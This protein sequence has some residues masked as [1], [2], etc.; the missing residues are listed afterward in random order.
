M[1]TIS[2]ESI[3]LLHEKISVT[4]DTIDYFPAFEKSLKD[5]SKKANISGFRPGKVPAG[6][7]K[8]M[9]GAALFSEEVFRAVDTELN[10]YFDKENI[11]FFAQPLPME[12]TDFP[13][14]DMNQPANY[15]FDFEIGLKPDFDLTD[16]SKI[17]LKEY[18]VDVTDEDINRKIENMQNRYAT[19]TETE[20]V[21][22]EDNNILEVTLE[23][24]DIAGN[25][26][27]Q[28]EIDERE[29]SLKKFSDNTR[30]KFYGK[31]TGDS[32]ELILDDTL[33]DDD[34]K[35]LDVLP[36]N[37]DDESAKNKK[38]KITITKVSRL[39]KRALNEAFFEEVYPGKN[40][41]TE[42]DLKAEIKDEM[43]R[44]WA[45]KSRNQVHHQLFHSLTDHIKIDFPETFLRRWLITQNK[46][47]DGATNKTEEQIDEEMPDFLNQLKW[48]VI[49]DKIAKEQSISVSPDEI[50]AF[51]KQQ[52]SSYMGIYF[53]TA[54]DNSW[55]NEYANRMLQDKKYVTETYN[56][57]QSEKI[58]SWAEKQ[59]TLIPT[60]IST[61]DFTTVMLEHNAQHH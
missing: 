12:T 49:S 27:E 41:K 5:Y 53:P 42:D 32:I 15:T 30:K 37:E 8:K 59:I 28:N 60:S 29:I 26:N 51:A 4:L 21:Q 25:S 18:Q 57:L 38:L 2:K 47:E 10:N 17:E 54:E 50:I 31:K 40:V 45:I 36:L 35:N 14:L 34:K 7:I 61:T 23:K 55:A 16:L 1:A 56:T 39:E 46:S 13:K 33:S 6:M 19:P 3:G 58:F 9:Y 22:E 11:D 52:L 48:S 24:W 44:Y 43:D 20:I